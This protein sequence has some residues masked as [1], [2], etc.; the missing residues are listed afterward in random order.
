MKNPRYIRK[1][2]V[3]HALRVHT[4]QVN[5][6]QASSDGTGQCDSTAGLQALMDLGSMIAWGCMG[7]EFCAQIPDAAW[8]GM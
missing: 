8:R 5:Q 4:S 2:K 1:F 6:F 7:Q 3:L